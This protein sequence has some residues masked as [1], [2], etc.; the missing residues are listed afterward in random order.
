MSVEETYDR[1]A[2]SYD[3]IYRAEGGGIAE[4]R[5]TLLRVLK[6]VLPRGRVLEVGCGIGNCV[7]ALAELG[8]DVTGIDISE[9]SLQRCRDLLERRRVTARLL[10]QDLQEAT[11]CGEFDAAI[12]LSSFITH[13]LSEAEQRE[14]LRRMRDALRPGGY[15][16]LS[17]YDYATLMAEED[18]DAVSSVQIVERDSR[19]GIYLQRRRWHGSPREPIHEC[20]YYVIFD[21]MADSTRISMRRRAIGPSELV[22]MLV[23]QGCGRV[24][25]FAPTECGYY[26]PVFV[27]QRE[28]F[29]AEVRDR[30]AEASAAMHSRTIRLEGPRALIV[31]TCCKANEP[32]FHEFLDALDGETHVHLV[33]MTRDA[34]DGR[35][36]D[37]DRL[38]ISGIKDRIGHSRLSQSYIDL[39][40]I[41]SGVPDA[42]I[43]SY[44]AAQA[45]MSWSFGR[46]D[47]V[48]ILLDADA[49]ADENLD[50]LNRDSADLIRTIART[51]D[52]P[53]VRLVSESSERSV[54]GE[55]DSATTS[56]RAQL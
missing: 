10:K 32:R 25:W 41:P 35:I 15:L 34:L 12:G 39:T 6:P 54:A 22:R 9:Q 20:T 56:R 14:C 53:W 44:F 36:D 1:W 28:S 21:D 8:Y 46:G 3:L 4:A 55:R 19:H 47:R 50:R 23:E 18:D 48:F 16:V 33:H 51:P 2:D 31:G 29:G 7:V 27:A 11:F 13:F 38:N 17:I 52:G 45:A 30:G 49:G 42:L 40:E 24:R 37:T 43:H 5:R 26:Q